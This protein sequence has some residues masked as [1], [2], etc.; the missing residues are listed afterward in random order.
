[1]R[2]HSSRQDLSHQLISTVDVSEWHEL[3]NTLAVLLP[4]PMPAAHLRGIP[5]SRKKS[6]A[7]GFRT[8]GEK[9]LYLA[10]IS[11]GEMGKGRL[12]FV[13]STDV[14]CVVHSPYTSITNS[15]R[16]IP[17]RE[18]AMIRITEVVNEVRYRPTEPRVRRGK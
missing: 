12:D 6:K 5:G 8:T 7:R 14:R 17:T 4:M 10:S 13:S 3:G 1:M 16:N 18:C 9:G 2:T 11:R 15:C